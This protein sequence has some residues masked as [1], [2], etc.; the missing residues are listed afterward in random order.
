MKIVQIVENPVVPCLQKM[1]GDQEVEFVGRNGIIGLGFYDDLNLV[2]VAMDSRT[3]PVKITIL[4]VVSIVGPQVVRRGK[5]V[6]LREGQSGRLVGHGLF[7]IKSGVRRQLKFEGDQ[8]VRQ[9]VRVLKCVPKNL[10]ETGALWKHADCWEDVLV[11]PSVKPFD[12]KHVVGRGV[13]F[14]TKCD[15]H[16][17][18]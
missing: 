9:V 11:R 3:L 13:R 1:L 15:V 2:V 7:Q 5:I 16:F 8:F 10:V 17:D 6:R 18:H 14:P 4:S 12:V